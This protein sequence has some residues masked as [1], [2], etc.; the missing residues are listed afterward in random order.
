[1]ADTIGAL[2]T[3]PAGIGSDP[4]SQKAY[5][6]ALSKVA[7]SLEARGNPNYFNIAAGFLKPTRTGSFG[8]SAGNA[9]EA[10]GQDQARQQEIAPNL[11]MMR[12]Q[13]QGQKY[14]IGNDAKL[15]AAQ[16]AFIADPNDKQAIATIA[17][18]DP[19]G[20]SGVIDL[21]KSAPKIRSLLGG[22]SNTETTPFDVLAMDHDPRISSQ[23]VQLQ[24]QFRSGL[25]DDKDGNALAQ[26]MLTLS[27]NSSDKKELH[28]LMAGVN[29]QLAQAKTDKINQ[30]MAGYL[31]PQQKMDYQ[32][33]ILPA[34]TEAG[35]AN[36][37][38]NQLDAMR[39]AILNAPSGAVAGYAAKYPG[40]VLNTD[41]NIALTKL[42]A[43]SKSLMTLIPHLPGSQ[44]NF[45]AKNL[46]A[47]LGE[48][49]N[50]NYSTKKRLALLDTVQSNFQKLA[51]R[52]YQIQQNWETNKTI[53]PV[54]TDRTKTESRPG[55]SVVA[56][57]E[58][59]TQAAAAI[60]QGADPIQVKAT[61]KKMTGKDY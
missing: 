35:K 60:A 52:G 32:K 23:A 25:I 39:E 10:M 34:I 29:Q 41:A 19:K 46:L 37:A 44:S 47:S 12:A 42:G 9:A 26:Q 6:D 5:I 50:P 61:F 1:M 49:D 2:P 3:A 28:G 4:D 58:L 53:D 43:D 15:K 22:T 33:I 30:E 24:K 38:L 27:I 31:N 16:Q 7:D 11:A 56:S 8:E 13:I 51:D 17:Q 45:D 55:A 18:Y 54:L 36:S 14:T 57:P 48:L 20:M 40:Q 21:A 59:R